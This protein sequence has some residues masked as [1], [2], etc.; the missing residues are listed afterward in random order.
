[1]I[2]NKKVMNCVKKGKSL[3]SK[4][5]I[6]GKEAFLLYQS[7]GFPIEQTIEEA[8]H[9]RKGGFRI[10]EKKLMKAFNKELAKHQSLSRTASS[11]TFK[12]GLSD[13]SKKTTRLH[14][15]THLLNE[16]LRQVLGKEVKQRGSNITPE[17]LRF[18]FSFSRKLTD[19]ELKEV[20][21]L[22]NKKIK[23]DL[24]V[25]SK[26]MLLS[27][28]LDFGAQSEFGHKYTKKVSVYTILD[29]SNKRGWFS[30]E[31]CTG[32]HVSNT[33]EI[34]RF[35]IT[36]EQSSAAGIRRIKAIIEN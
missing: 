36:K 17:R 34:G 26:E 3:K 5:T 19:K 33:K 10:D 32:P 6:S 30:K 8:K 15:A 11:G 29:P 13:S 25:T 21:N 1:M 28:A 4:I 18:D 35:K 23:A 7:Y 22:V 12:S 31:V 24:K 2:F 27:K 14:T 9:F 16:A 20:E